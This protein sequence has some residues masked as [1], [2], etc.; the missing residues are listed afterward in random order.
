ML[1]KAWRLRLKALRAENNS[2]EVQ[3]AHRAVE[4]L[5]ASDARIAGG[6][7]PL[8]SE[9]DV[10]QMLMAWAVVAPDRQLALPYADGCGGLSYRLWRP[11]EAFVPDGAGIP[12]SSGP[13]V[14]P[15]FVLTP[16]LG[17]SESC[18]RLGYGGG[19]FDRWLAALGARRPVLCGI[20]AEAC[21]V[22][23]DV[24]AE[25]DLPLDLIA[26]ERRLLRLRQL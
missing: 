11:G 8:G 21:L 6:Y 22:P 9:P 5:A 10:L 12:S 15:D 7:S 20:A 2:A 19:Y 3:A 25:H 14:L 18:R 1:K 24:F 16:C 26:T 4:A 17:F 23:E 13:S